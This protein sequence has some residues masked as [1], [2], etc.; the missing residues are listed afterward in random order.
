MRTIRHVIDLGLLGE[1]AIEVTYSYS[2]GRP[3]RMYMPNGDP[4]YPDEPA[5]WE[6]LDFS[7]PWELT[8]LM[9]AAVYDALMESVDLENEIAEWEREDSYDYNEEAYEPN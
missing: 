6:L 9:R 5:E 3:G 7:F 8:P 4:G 2:P 1:H